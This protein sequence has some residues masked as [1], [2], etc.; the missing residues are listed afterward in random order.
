MNG[1]TRENNFI[2]EYEEDVNGIASELKTA[3]GALEGL[4]IED[5]LTLDENSANATK[6]QKEGLDALAKACADYDL[7]LSDLLDVLSEFGLVQ[8]RIDFDL[9]EAIFDGTGKSA[10][11]LPENVQQQIE[12]LSDEVKLKLIEELNKA[13]NQFRTE[14]SGG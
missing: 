14:N 8:S 9:R 4:S 6:E 7:E 12:G 3:M 5:I 11:S 10:E 13:D 2:A 1:K